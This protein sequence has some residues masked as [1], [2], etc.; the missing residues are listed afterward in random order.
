MKRLPFLLVLSASL[1]FLA[2]CGHG[3]KQISEDQ[4]TFQR[5]QQEDSLIQK[6]VYRPG[7]TAPY[8]KGKPGGTWRNNLTNELKT[9]N[10]V[11]AV[12]DAESA[13]ITDNLSSY[14]LEY[15]AYKKQWKP[16]A[17]SSYEVSVNDAARTMDVTFTLRDDLYWTTLADPSRKVKVT[18]DD[19]VFWYN[20]IEGDPAF[21]HSGYAGQFV[22]MPDGKKK[23]IDMEKIDERRFVFHYPRI[24]AMPELSSNR[25]FGPRYIFEEAKKKGGVEGVLN[26]WSVNTDPRTI[27]S[28]G[29]YYIESN[30][31][32]IQATLARNPNYWKT[33]DYGQKIPYIER[34][35]TKIIPS[36]DTEKLKFLAGELDGYGLRPEDLVDMT[37]KKTQDYTVYY[38]GPSLGA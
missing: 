38:N 11:V 15:D 23:H 4:L 8:E 37:S 33:D 3:V 31:P 7:S 9:F 24:V 34:Y 29:P 6:T 13:G 17:A 19:V 14:L 36:R 35:E 2:A 25:N 5:K 20:E 21:Q 28:M 16:L 32:G 12:Y 1:A 10:P 22:Q 27:P 30:K 26:L 18:S